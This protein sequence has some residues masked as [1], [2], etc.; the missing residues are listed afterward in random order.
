MSKELD[1]RLRPEDTA[2]RIGSLVLRI[3]QLERQVAVLESRVDE[4]DPPETNDAIGGTD[5]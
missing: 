3:W 5:A 1:I 4:L 2:L